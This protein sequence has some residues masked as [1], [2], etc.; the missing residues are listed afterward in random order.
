MKKELKSDILRA[1][2]QVRREARRE[3]ITYRQAAYSI[4]IK[5]IIN[6]V[7]LGGQL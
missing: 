3:G 1:Y 4:A 6:R 2:T 5:R 7:R